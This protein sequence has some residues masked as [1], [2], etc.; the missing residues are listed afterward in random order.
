MNIGKEELKAKV[1]KP[2]LILAAVALIS[3]FLLS[4]VN[5]STSKVIKARQLEKQTQ[6]V[7]SVLFGYSN[8]I[9]EKA[10]VDG[11]TVNY[12]VGSREIKDKK[13]EDQEN[14]VIESKIE[15]A[16]AMLASEPGY[17]GNI[18]TMVGFNSELKVLEIVILHQT[19]TPG[20]G[21]VCV[22][23][24]DDTTLADIVTGK[25]KESKI[26]R[27]W[28]Q[29]QFVGLSMSEPVRIEH[30]GDW[31]LQMRDELL[32]KNAITAITGATITSRAVLNSV[33]HKAQ[34]LKKILS[35]K[36]E[37]EKSEENENNRGTE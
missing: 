12:W 14:E 30:K 2:A 5:R 37:K 11:E 26:K 36:R 16:Y 23:V 3:A 17:S 31:T 28:F 4:H 21:T 29:E 7:K 19:E 24:A 15:K 35:A 34:Q 13:N 6:A 33:E 1:L 27:P 9:E 22:E 25:K 10:I 20:L 32:K 18:N 8:I